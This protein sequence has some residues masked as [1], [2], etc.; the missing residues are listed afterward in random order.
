MLRNVLLGCAASLMMPAWGGEIEP[1][2]YAN[3]PVDVNF[4][5]AGAIYSD[6]ALA[7]S[8]ASPLKDSQLKVNTEVLAYARTLDVWGKSAKFDAILPYSHLSGTA[9]VA[10]QPRERNVAGFNDPLMRLSVNLYGAPALSLPDFRSYQQDLIVGASVQLSAPLGQYDSSKLV[11]LGNNRWFVKPE[12]GVSKAMGDFTLELSAAAF[13]FSRNDDYFGGKTLKQDPIY[14]AQLHGT[15]HFSNG[16][17]FSLS[18]AY[19]HGGDTFVN[20]VS[21]DN[22]SDNWR[23]GATLS[24]PI[25]KNNSLKIYGSNG[26]VTRRG[27]DFDLFGLLYMYRWGGGL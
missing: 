18:S 14:T 23:L 24:L 17:W 7:N 13:F 6:G 1:R 11:N 10:G 19:D 15:Y 9:M 3:A 4:F 8:A 26:L 20:G 22:Q 2:A 16:I 12:I 5:V 21:S 27:T 25:N